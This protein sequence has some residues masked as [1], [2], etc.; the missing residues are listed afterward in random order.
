MTDT[1]DLNAELDRLRIE[2]ENTQDE[3]MYYIDVI[4]DYERV[5]ENSREVLKSLENL[6][7]VSERMKELGIITPEQYFVIAKKYTVEIGGMTCK[8]RHPDY[9]NL[10][11]PYITRISGKISAEYYRQF[12]KPPPMINKGR[13]NAYTRDNYILFADYIINTYVKAHPIDNLRINWGW[14]P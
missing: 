5:Y 6:V 2:L 13:S 12:N 14:H 8:I 9:D 3:N 1:K 4:Q 10:F 11:W 7:K